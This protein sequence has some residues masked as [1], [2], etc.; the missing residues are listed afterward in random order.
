VIVVKK[1]H[2]DRWNEYR[3]FRLEALQREP[4]AFGSSYDE[5]VSIPEEVWRKRIGN[6]LFALSKGRLI[7]IIVC[8]QSDRIKTKH[9]ANIF[10]F[11]VIEKY[12]G[13]GLGKKLIDRALTEVQKSRDVV[14]IKLTVN[15]EQ[16]VALKLYRKFGFKIA[17]RCKKELYVEG[18]FYD[19][20]IMEKML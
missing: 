14:K 18:R 19:E 12:R 9:V 11:Y 16:K 7:G 4:I 13:Q 20:L 5:E 2:E 15:P 3:D 17:G 8:V 6:A 10:S 1:L